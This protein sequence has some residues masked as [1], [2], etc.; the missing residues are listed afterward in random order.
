MPKN[1]TSPR[2]NSQ[3][4]KLNFSTGFKR[5]IAK[6]LKKD[7]DDRDSALKIENDLIKKYK[8]KHGDNPDGNINPKN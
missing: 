6:I 5:F 1:N 4:N 2:A 3:I 7:I 8:N